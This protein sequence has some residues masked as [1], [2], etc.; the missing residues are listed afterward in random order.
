VELPL[1]VVMPDF[2]MGQIGQAP[3]V[4]MLSAGDGWA[5]LEALS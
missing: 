5:G 4:V 3:E 1:R 2:P